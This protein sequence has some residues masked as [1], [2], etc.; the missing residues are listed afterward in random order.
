M[1]ECS[2][3]V[4]GISIMTLVSFGV[5]IF[6]SYK[7]PILIEVLEEY[8]CHSPE[9]MI[10]IMYGLKCS[11]HY[12]WLDA[13]LGLR[14][15]II[16]VETFRNWWYGFTNEVIVSTAVAHLILQ[17]LPLP[18]SLS[19]HIAINLFLQQFT[20]F[21]T[22]STFVRTGNGPNVWDND[23]RT[24][25][26]EVGNY[27]YANTI[28]PG[29]FVYYTYSSLEIR[30]YKIPL[31]CNASYVM[32]R[33]FSP[34]L[35]SHL[36]SFRNSASD[37]DSPDL[38]RSRLDNCLRSFSTLGEDRVYANHRWAKDTLEHAY[39]T[40]T[41]SNLPVATSSERVYVYGSLAETVSKFCP[42]PPLINPYW[43]STRGALDAQPKQK[44]V[45]RQVFASPGSFVRADPDD[46]MTQLLAAHKRVAVKM[47]EPDPVCLVEVEQFTTDFLELRGV[48]PLSPDTSLDFCL[49]LSRART[50]KPAKKNF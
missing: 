8:L 34:E 22:G 41:R 47:P 33:W 29:Y 39:R 14:L 7:F 5:V 4:P 26:R 16:I 44:P 37:T 20:Y 28:L 43:I 31:G 25:D 21:S 32:D 35:F 30:G 24:Y 49:G 23:K 9:I 10:D 36:L 1:Y 2:Y 27:E 18:I 38:V 3:V 45:A 12:P 13:G 15:I 17:I 6:L 42:L 50:L 46:V 40:I 19:L 48:K 11:I